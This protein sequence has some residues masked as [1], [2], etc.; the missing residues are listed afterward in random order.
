[1]ITYFKFRQKHF[2]SLQMSILNLCTPELFNCC[3][4]LEV[5]RLKKQ[6]QLNYT[7]MERNSFQLSK[8]G[9]SKCC[10]RSLKCTAKI[11]SIYFNLHLIFELL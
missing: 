1:M 10:I 4:Q 6:P 8:N 7:G 3:F 11:P 5:I 2:F 9:K